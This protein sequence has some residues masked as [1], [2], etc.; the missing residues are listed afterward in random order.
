MFE[1]SKG[2]E[3]KFLRVKDLLILKAFLTSREFLRGL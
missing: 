2:F 1:S 3:K